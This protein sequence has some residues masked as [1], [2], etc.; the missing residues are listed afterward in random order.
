[1]YKP[2]TLLVVLCAALQASRPL[3]TGTIDETQR[4]TLRGSVHPLARAQFDRGP[5]PDSLVLRHLRILLRRPPEQEQTLR[6]FIDQLHDPASPSFH[7]W[8]TP[9]Q[10]GEQFGASP[11]DIDA[12]AAWLGVHGFEIDRVYPNRMAIEFSGTA[13]QVRE[14]FHAAVHR[15]IVNGQ[16]H[17]ALSQDPRIPA[18]LAPAI[19]GIA[20]LNDFPAHPAYHQGG[21]ARRNRETGKWQFM[22]PVADA[23]VSFSGNDYYLIA[24]YDFATIYNLSPLW[25]AGATGQNE[26][27]ALVEDSAI[28]PADVDAFR[29]GLGLPAMQPGQLQI[30]CVTGPSCATTPD[31]TEGAIDAEWSGAVAPSATILY[32]AADTLEDAAAYIVGNNAAPVVSISYSACE[33]DLGGGNAFWAGLWQTASLQGQTIVAAAGDSGGAVCDSDVSPTAPYAS[34]GLSVNG[35]ASSIYNVAIGGTDFSDTFAGTNSAYWASGNSALT[36]QSALSYVPEMTWNNSCASNVLSGFLGFPRGEATCEIL[37]FFFG[38]N[39][40]NV[41]N[42]VA[43]A[44]GPSSLYAKPTWQANV[45]GIANDG[46]RDLPDV[47]LF[48]SDNAWSHA[49]IYCMSDPNENGN[50]CDYSDAGDTVFNSG[51][52]TSFAAPAFAGIM[53]LVVQQTGSAQGNANAVLYSLAGNEYGTTGTPNTEA[54]AACN[55]GQGNQVSSTCLFYD[56]TLGDTTVPCATGS[57]NCYTV[58]AGDAQGVLSTS[59]ASLV[60]AYQAGTGWDF[61]TG[62]G[63]VNVANLV[64]GWGTSAADYVI[65]GQVTL[66]GAGLAGAAVSLTGGRHGSA[67]TN[68]SG[69]YTFVVPGN[70]TYLVTPALSGFTF[71][72]PS[73]NFKNLNGNRTANFAGSGSLP[74][75]ELSTESLGF[76]NQNAGVASASEAV[77]LTNTGNGPLTLTALATSGVDAADFSVTAGCGTLPAQIAAEATCTVRIVFTPSMAGAESATL[78][79]T[80]NSSGKTGSTQA[81]NLTGT[82]IVTLT[83]SPASVSFDYAGVNIPSEPHSV[84][85][86]NASAIA[87]E[88]S[89]ITMTGTHAGDFKPSSK[90]GALASGSK[91]AITV[92]FDPTATGSRAATLSIADSATGS[93]Q[94]VALTGAGTEKAVIELSTTSLT[95]PATSVGQTSAPQVV[96]VTNGGHAALSIIGVG[97]SDGF[98][99]TN[100]CTAALSSGATCTVSVTFTP[101][102]TGTSAGT[103]TVT[104]NG[105]IFNQEARL[106]GTG[107]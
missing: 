36:L 83:V 42:I 103:L 35:I 48:A 57:P 12:L 45:A 5:A 31:E 90:C 9:Q 21:R 15:Y 84:E 101:I 33:S 56:V 92:V 37:P 26:T 71:N 78:T 27:I 22:N 100:T 61:A 17:W 28:N 106:T 11:Q 25:N 13:S 6:E 58:S 82:G 39:P 76:G 41:L 20:K 89:K 95:F 88:I 67:V 62:L 34:L 70:R 1:M 81:V 8:L 47:S 63:S 50:P 96:T 75:A 59:G 23:N 74:V 73:Q 79:F 87:V 97:A 32:V 93:P 104:G 55:A 53:A 4:V 98:A 24:P 10:T 52:G 14:A 77:V 51:G 68:S 99:Q 40:L 105:V 46:V 91:C 107:K 85:I 80:D 49:Y 43:G 19:A 30:M 60:P 18:A 29:T 94:T 102:Q 66:N 2:F 3:I 54:L 38:T 7:R 72:P 65:S 86:A 69:K 16:E 64:G 44:G